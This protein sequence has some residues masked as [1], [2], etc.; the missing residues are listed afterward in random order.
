VR[1]PLARQGT[2]TRASRTH[3]ERTV[4]VLETSDGLRGVRE[5]RGMQAAEIINARFANACLMTFQ[6]S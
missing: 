5:T 3:A 2:F 6:G 1:V 4:V